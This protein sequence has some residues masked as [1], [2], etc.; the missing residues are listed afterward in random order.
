MPYLPSK[1]GFRIS[2][3]NLIKHL[4]RRHKVDLI[5]LLRDE[6]S[7]HIDWIAKYCESVFTVPVRRTSLPRRLAGFLSGYA[8][9]KQLS[10]RPEVVSA[11]RSGFDRKHWDVL[12]AE[13]G[14]VGGLV[15]SDLPVA[16]VLA[17]HDAE[18]LRAQEILKCDVNVR[19]RLRYTARTYYERRYQ[20]LV[21]PRFER[22]VFVAERDMVF[23]QSIVPRAA[24]EVIPYGVDVDYFQPMPVEKQKNELVFHGHLGYAPNIQAA[25]EFADNIFPLILCKAPSA[26]LHLVGASPAPAICALASRPR[27]RLSADLPDLRAAVSSAEIYVCPLRYGSGIKN[28]TLEAMAME[29]PIVGYPGSTA[30]IT[31][32]PGKHMLVAETPAQF[33]ASV[34]NLLERP[35]YARE[36][37]E[38]GRRLM[39]DKY[40]W[41]SM[42]AAYENLYQ[43]V[44]DERAAPQFQGLHKNLTVTAS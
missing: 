41:E 22:C 31:C 38:A 1:G 30:G 15:P 10:C 14:F 16:K 3:A 18:V 44:I 4:C 20:R 29:L 24:F 25:I 40:S 28:K 34:L 5:S 27:I 42:A 32:V 36:I 6:D 2:G 37:A 21:Y 17:V 12:H 23:N 9:G 8:I 43:Q 33:A 26:T 39:Q 35:Q 19:D 7:Q 13:G 11:L